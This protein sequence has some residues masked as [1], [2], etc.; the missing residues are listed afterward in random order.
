MNLM[1]HLFKLSLLLFLLASCQSSPISSTDTDNASNAQTSPPPN[2]ILIMADDLGYKGISCYGNQ[3]IQTPHLDQLAA[4]GIRFTDYHANCTVC[5]PTRAALLTG[6]YQQR[7]GLEGVIYVRGPTR[8][9][10]MSLDEIT[11]AELLKQRGYAT[12]IMGKWH[13]GYKKEYFPTRQGFDEFYGYVSGN[14]DFHSH[15]DNSGIY[16]WWHNEDSLIEQGYVTDLITRHSV[17]FIE[18]HQ[19]S[20]FFL[21]VAHQAP[22]APFQG[23]EDSAYRFPN[24]EFSYYGNVEDKEAAYV[25]MVEVM[26]EGIGKIMETVDRLG[27]AEHTLIIFVSDNGAEQHYGH[28]G[29]LRGWKTT[30]FEGGIRVPA[31]VRWK[32]HISPAVSDELVMS[33]DWMPTLLALSQIP[34]PDALT[35]DGI[36]ITPLLL[37]QSPLTERMLFWRYRQQKAVREGDWKLLL[38][39]EQGPMLFNLKEDRGEQVNLAEKYEDKVMHMKEAIIS[40]EQE[41]YGTRE[42]LTQ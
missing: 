18:K 35:L 3:D 7:S 16:D 30:L 36:D 22:H 27:L 38:D 1:P 33:F 20:S 12:G 24:R 4:E 32:N 19:D 26:D 29:E 10:G 5:T 23:R 14:I 11:L 21:Y 17:D 39:E 34:I 25:E 9:L 40:W 31:I 28:N 37:D 13:L 6:R 2:V 15:Y 41:V 8:Q 42:M